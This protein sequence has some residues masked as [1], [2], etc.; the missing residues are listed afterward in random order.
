MVSR[1]IEKWKKNLGTQEEV[2]QPQEEDKAGLG[3]TRNI[4]DSYNPVG[5]QRVA[6]YYM[7]HN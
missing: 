1:I 5:L 7:I 2:Q 4:K 6:L 3:S